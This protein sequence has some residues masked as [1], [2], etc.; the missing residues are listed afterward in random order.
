[1]RQEDRIRVVCDE[2]RRDV[3]CPEERR[4]IMRTST[5]VKHMQDKVREMSK[6]V[7]AKIGESNKAQGM[8]ERSV[9][10]QV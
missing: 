1:M 2:D 8:H 10:Q 6:C 5:I 3:E 9:R 4:K 7:S